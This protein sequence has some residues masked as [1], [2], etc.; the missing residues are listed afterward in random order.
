MQQPVGKHMPA[1]RIGAHL[2]FINT[3]KFNLLGHRHGL[4]RA[5]KITGCLGQNAFFAGNQR[6]R[7]LADLGHRTVIIFARQKTQREPDHPGRVCQHPFHGQ[8]GL[9]GVGRPQYGKDTRTGS[10]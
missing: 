7:T 10:G 3:Q 8:M 9:A 6:H 4:D 5:H 1:F 2:D